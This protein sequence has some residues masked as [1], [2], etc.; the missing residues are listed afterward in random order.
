MTTENTDRIRGAAYWVSALLSTLIFA[1][2]IG[3]LTMVPGVT[4]SAK[5]SM[6]SVAGS[7]ALISLCIGLWRFGSTDAPALH[8]PLGPFSMVILLLEIAECT[9]SI[10]QIARHVHR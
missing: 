1:W 5:S 6:L 8:W 9:G 3:T 2:A 10:F 7:A 4:A